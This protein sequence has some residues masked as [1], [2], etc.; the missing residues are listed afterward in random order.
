[1]RHWRPHWKALARRYSIDWRALSLG[2]ARRRV[3]LPA[4]PFERQRYFADLPAGQPLPLT[5]AAVDGE[6]PV[7]EV[8]L[9]ATAI[10][11]DASNV[12]QS[13][14]IE[15]PGVDDDSLLVELRQLLGD[16]S[17]ADLATAPVNANILELGFDSLILSQAALMLSRK[18]G[19]PIT[20]RQLLKDLGTLEALAA[21]LAVGRKAPVKT[22]AIPATAARDKTRSNGSQASTTVAHGPFRPVQRELGASLT[23]RQQRWLDDFIARYATRTAASK[24]YTQQHR[25]HLADPRAA[26]GF[27]QA[28]K[29]IV[30]PI[31]VER[32]AGAKLWDIDGNEWTDITLSFG[33]AMLGHQPPFV[34]EAITTQLARGMEIGPTSPL[35]G[36]V[37]ALLC[38]LTGMERATF[39]NT[40]SE[41]M[42]GASRIARTVTGRSRIAYFRESYHGIA[43]EVLGR[44]TGSG[45]VPIAPGIPPEAVANALILDYGD[46]RS[47][48]IIAAHAN[49]I[50][51]VLVEPVQ[52]RRP[53]FQP[54]EFLH[55]LRTLTARQGIAL[56]FDEVIT[57][58][59][60]ALG[61]AQEHFG[62]KADIAT[63]GKVIG[64]GLPIGAI[65]GRAGF[66]DAFDGG[67]W[68]FGDGSFPEAAV[69]FFAGRSCV[70]RSRWRLRAPSSRISNRTAMRSRK[71]SQIRRRRCSLASTRDLP[72]RLSSRSTSLPTGC[73]TPR[74]SSNIRRCFSRC[75]AIAAFIFGKAARV[76][77]QP[78]TPR[79]TSKKLS[80]R[81]AR[82]SPNW[83]TQAFSRARAPRLSS[84]SRR[85][86]QTESR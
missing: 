75:C 10:R 57:G 77:F 51:A 81:S 39:C 54:R 43:D 44:A 62:V 12:S 24:R 17:G 23:E 16:L 67:H 4:Y 38:E 58:F 2:Q 45:V 72:A 14:T 41:A 78:R 66:M 65:A 5:T 22:A 48:E 19:V 42:S 28:W 9:S 34:V 82:V 13:E 86:R 79:P 26:A 76:F 47:L 64:G 70:T 30:Y 37:A 18:F 1:M 71:R 27:K 56:I 73:C 53:G 46:P 55:E 31:V 69:T 8:A 7:E 83:K 80:W 20:F 50:A 63:F 59:R 15:A 32:S 68:S 35:A 85:V 40:G 52:S 60:C 49:E 11:V 36:E 25:R 61:G 33:A 84:L 6:P 74:R 29:E 3:S 21:H